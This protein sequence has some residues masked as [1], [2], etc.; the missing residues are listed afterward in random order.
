[1]LTGRSSPDGI[2]FHTALQLAAKGAKVYVGA[3][4]AAKAQEAIR[5]M[6]NRDTSIGANRLHPFVADLGNL[7]AVRTAA[8]NLMAATNR[9]DILINNAGL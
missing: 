7:K 6:R 5:E 8:E 9:L 2:G 4:S 1:L 3:R